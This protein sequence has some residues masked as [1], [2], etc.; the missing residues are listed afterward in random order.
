MDQGSLFEVGDLGRGRS[1]F[2]FFGVRY[3]GSGAQSVRRALFRELFFL[4]APLLLL[5]RF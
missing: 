1:V 5:C 2:S 4:A 3:T